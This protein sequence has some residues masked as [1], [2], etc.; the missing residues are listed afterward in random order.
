MYTWDGRL[1]LLTNISITLSLTYLHFPLLSCN[2]LAYKALGFPSLKTEERAL[3][4][5]GLIELNGLMDGELTRLK[6]G[7]WATPH[8]AWWQAGHGSRQ[9][10]AASWMWR[11]TGLGRRLCSQEEGE[12]AS[13]RGNW[14]P[15]VCSLVTRETSKGAHPSQPLW[16]EQSPTGTWGKLC[17]KVNLVLKVQ[18]KQALGKQGRQRQQ[19][20]SC[21][22]WPD[23]TPI[24][25]IWHKN[26]KK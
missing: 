19:E 12:V 22:K 20:N 21:L 15:Q 24:Q 14:L 11:Q 7:P 23:H 6:Q 8:R 2:P 18:M 1:R 17:R 16:K 26:L 5:S 4:Q 3:S 13:Y 25:S 9:D 10:K